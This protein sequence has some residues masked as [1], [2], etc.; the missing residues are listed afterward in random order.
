MSTYQPTSLTSIVQRLRLI[1]FLMII[2]EALAIVS[3]LSFGS[4]LFEI[5]GDKI[6]G[7]LAG[8]GSFGGAAVMPMFIYIYA[9]RAPLR[10]RGL[11]YLAMLENA[12]AILFCVFHL[13]VGNLEVQGAFLTM[14]VSAIFLVAFLLNLP[15][16][17]VS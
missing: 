17:K 11:L 10:Y 6:S 12:A 4:F 16:G 3:E 2:W 1:L 7:I 5:S 8:R 15:R 13:A 9:L 14:V